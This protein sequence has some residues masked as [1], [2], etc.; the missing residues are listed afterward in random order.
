M[1][2]PLDLALL[3]LTTVG[4]G[5]SLFVGMEAVARA[6]ARAS[7]VRTVAFSGGEYSPPAVLAPPANGRAWQRPEFPRARGKWIFDLFTPPLIRLDPVRGALVTAPPRL[8]VVAAR[9]ANIQL[10]LEL[11]A[12]RPRLYRFRLAGFAGSAERP[13]VTLEDPATGETFLLRSGTI[14]EAHGLEARRFT[15]RRIPVATAAAGG[16]GV[17][18]EVATAVLFDL[19]E[20]REVI[21]SSAGPAPGGDLIGVFRS[22]EDAV[23]QERVAGETLIVAGATYTVDRLS[24]EPPSAE[25]AGADTGNARAVLRL[26]PAAAAP[27]STGPPGRV[28]SAPPNTAESSDEPRASDAPLLR[29]GPDGGDP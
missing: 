12:V 13:V 20:H 10:P 24:L 11:V 8:E 14:D 17:G 22:G 3:G 5:V 29:A 27:G 28:S 16:A 26:V 2:H 9:V 18:E 6:S 15:V 4:F 1:K 23:V 25:L 21:L 19:R 7:G